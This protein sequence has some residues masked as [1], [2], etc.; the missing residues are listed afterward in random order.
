MYVVLVAGDRATG[1]NSGDNDPGTDP[2]DP[3]TS[4][5]PSDATSATSEKGGAIGQLEFYLLMV[6]VLGLR[7][8]SGTVRK[9][10]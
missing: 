7:I 9:N 3:G 8:V 4:S 1:G 5:L 10:R 2:T 6:L